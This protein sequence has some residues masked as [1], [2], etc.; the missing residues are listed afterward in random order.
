MTKAVYETTVSPGPPLPKSH[1]FPSLIAKLYI[2]CASSYS[3]AQSL[4]KTLGDSDVSPD[5]RKYLVH[6]NSFTLALVYKWLGVDAG[7]SGSRTGIAVGFLSLAKTELES[8]HNIKKTL[9]GKG[10]DISKEN[11]SWISTE[12]SSVTVFFKSYRKLNDTV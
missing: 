10:G 11:K 5:L 3:S 8:L 9:L 1:P 2:H 7:E 6:E 12:M 4:A